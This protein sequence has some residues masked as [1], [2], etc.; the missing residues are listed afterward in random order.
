MGK[1]K[2]M[3]LTVEGEIKKHANKLMTWVIFFL[4]MCCCC[5]MKLLDLSFVR[6]LFFTQYHL[7]FTHYE[8]IGKII[9]N[10]N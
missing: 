7:D 1:V 2:K 8:S 9:K 5:V 4:S 3:N 10:L 6:R